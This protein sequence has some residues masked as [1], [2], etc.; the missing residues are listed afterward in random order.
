[1]LPLDV[2]AA[3]AELT[4]P[5]AW[6]TLEPVR[7]G[8]L[9]AVVAVLRDASR[10]A[11]IGGRGAVLSGAGPALQRLGELTGVRARHHRGGQ[12]AVRG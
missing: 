12:R 4:D 7:P 5:P 10:P 11:I 6:P 8:G 2:Q 9:D 3:P 1:M